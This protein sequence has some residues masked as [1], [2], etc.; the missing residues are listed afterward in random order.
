MLEALDL[1]AGLLW[2]MLTCPRDAAVLRSTLLQPPMAAAAPY[3]ISLFFYPPSHSYVYS[4]ISFASR[5]RARTRLTERTPID[6]RLAT[7]ESTLARLAVVS[8]C[9]YRDSSLL[10][11]V[12]KRG[13]SLFHVTPFCIPLKSVL[14]G[15]G[16]WRSNFL[17]LC[18][19][20]C[21]ATMR[22]ILI[23]FVHAIIIL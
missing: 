17:L 20:F 8:S 6:F 23:S 18:K 5:G 16:S 19:C 15:H 14:E 9:L 21:L 11:T 13:S 4:I 12:S 10:R 7:L 1:S 3:P 2:G 22:L